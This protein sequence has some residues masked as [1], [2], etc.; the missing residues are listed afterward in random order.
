MTKEIGKYIQSEIGKLKDATVDTRN[1]QVQLTEKDDVQIAEQMQ[2][3]GFQSVPPVDSKHLVIDL[4]GGWKISFAEND[5]VAPDASLAEGESKIF[6]SDA[7]AIQAFANFLKTGIIELN[8][9][10]DF[11]VR[12]LALETAFN[13]L[14][15][16]H[17]SL[18]TAFN[19]LVTEMTAHTHIYAPG[20]GTP[21]ATAPTAPPPTPSAEG[22]STGDVSGA[23]IDNI[24][25]PA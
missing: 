2:L 17:D 16:D 20:P 21:I 24:K 9:N 14:K 6:S 3:S 25:V 15:T 13:Q 5:G 1:I 18:V 10:T 11:A 8:G 7:G 19:T 4:G 23:K 22:P 12:Y